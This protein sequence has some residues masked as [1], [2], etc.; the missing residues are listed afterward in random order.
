MPWNSTTPAG[1][2]PQ[3]VTSDFV[4]P[5]YDGGRLVAVDVTFLSM[6]I[7]MMILRLYTQAVL[8]KRVGLDDCK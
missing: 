2:P 8:S 3:G 4:S 7:I 6:A 5:Q 1:Q